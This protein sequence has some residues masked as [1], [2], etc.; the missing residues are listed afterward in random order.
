MA[1]MIR[2]FVVRLSHAL[3][4]IAAWM[5]DRESPRKWS[6]SGVFVSTLGSGNSELR[7]ILAA[8]SLTILLRGHN[9]MGDHKRFC[10]PA[11]HAG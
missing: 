6:G 11:E 3:L 8:V 1:I 5:R 10:V 2:V 7:Q 9:R 4:R